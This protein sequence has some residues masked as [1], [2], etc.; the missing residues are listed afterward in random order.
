MAGGSKLAVMSAIVA[1]SLVACAKFAG[2]AV[3]GSGSML[4]EGIHS[5][6][7]VGNQSLLAVGMARSA[8][9]ADESHPAGYQ[10]D[11]FKAG[12]VVNFLLSGSCE[13]IVVGGNCS[14]SQVH[15]PVYPS[16]A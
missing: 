14:I 5:L 4:S 15:L 10:R 9:P 8:R 16:L 2:F 7:D 12:K 3:T 11:A 1:N 6:A 13:Y